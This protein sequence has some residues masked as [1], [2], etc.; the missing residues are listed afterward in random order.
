[1]SKPPNINVLIIQTDEQSCWTLGAYGGELVETP[2]IDSIGA[3]G[4]C[5]DNFFTVS[6]V[7][8]PSR[9]CFLTGR[10]PHSHKAFRNNEQIG[11]D[12]LTLAHV[13]RDAGYDTG[14]AGKWHLNGGD[15]AEWIAPDDAMGF[16]DC[17]H[18]FNGGHQKSVVVPPEGGPPVKSRDMGDEKTHMTDWLADRTIEFINQPRTQPF[19][20]ML[21][22]PDPHGPFRA[23]APYD[24]MFD[25]DAMP[26]PDSFNEAH[27]PDWAEHDSWGRNGQY[28]LDL[29]D[30]EDK[31]RRVKAQYCGMVKHIDDCVG[32]ILDALRTEGTLDDTV[33]VFTSDHGDYMG[34]HGLAAKNNLYDSVYRIP[35]LIRWPKRISG[36]TV[37][38]PIVSIIDFQQSLLSLLGIPPCGREQGRDATP[39][40]LGEDVDWTEEVF[41]HPSDVP[42]AGIITPEYELAYVGRGWGEGWGKNAPEFKDHILFDRIDDPKQMHNLFL[43]PAK[44]NVIGSLM[45]RIV[46]HYCAVESPL[47]PWLEE[48]SR[49]HLTGNCP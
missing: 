25:P 18:M 15:H 43:D 44:Q 40:I 41:I 38:R 7:C 45:A 21:S 23:R 4:V 29:P 14:Y 27:I 10:Y 6:A 28:P 9:G 3:E 30:R 31:L 42:R 37:V 35:L 11:R 26:I 32:R 17:R 19:F 16:D 24:T 33:V 5:F 46:A 1:M 2:H 20:Y 39:L 49:A 34:E 48:R 13:L 36:G 12:E 22:I 8:T 47:V